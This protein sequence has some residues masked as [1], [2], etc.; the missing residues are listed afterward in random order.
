LIKATAH[1]KLSPSAQTLTPSN[2][3]I[4]ISPSNKLELHYYFSDSSHT[5]NAVLRNACERELLQLFKGVIELLAFEIDIESE[6]FSEGGLKEKWTLLG[7]HATQLTLIILVINL[8]LSRIPVENKEL[9]N[10]QIENLKLDNELKRDELNKIKEDVN[11]NGIVTEEIVEKVMQALDADYKLIWHKSAFY[12]KLNYYPKVTKISTRKLDKNDNPVG[13]EKAVLK[14]QFGAFILR[15]DKLPPLIDEEAVIDIISPVLKKGNFQWKGFYKGQIISFEMK[16]KD[17]KESVRN[18]EIE[19]INGTA[20][21]CVLKQNRKIDELGL[22]QVVSNQVLTV[23]EIIE[24]DNI[25]ETSQGER[26]KRNN[27]HRE[28]QL[29]MDL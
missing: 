14:N 26:Y 4:M 12:K 27:Q 3:R 23:I 18:K 2:I 13:E 10:L 9:I 20:I 24:S 6:A 5:I 15:S 25:Q 17:F 28:A 7:K 21:K 1:V 16:D 22:I 29:K 19:F 11:Q 8:F